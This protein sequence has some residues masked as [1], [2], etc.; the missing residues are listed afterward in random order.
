[1]SAIPV[2]SLSSAT[3]MWKNAKALEEENKRLRKELEEWVKKALELSKRLHASG[4]GARSAAGRA[5]A[6][7]AA[8][9]ASDPSTSSAMAV[10]SVAQ[11]HARFKSAHAAPRSESA[12]QN[13]PCTSQASSS[14]GR[15][16]VESRVREPSPI[17]PRGRAESLK[18]ALERYGVPSTGR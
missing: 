14:S 6:Q 4:A 16:A 7:N 13:R 8:T 9:Q 12:T 2:P 10:N 18:L 15:T 3:E 11:M 5:C 1:M 17:A